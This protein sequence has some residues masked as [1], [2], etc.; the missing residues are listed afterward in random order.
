MPRRYLSPR[1]S[2]HAT[3]QP[4]K[5]RLPSRPASVL[6][7]VFIDCCST[8]TCELII[9]LHFLRLLS[10][11]SASEYLSLGLLLMFLSSP[12][13]YDCHEFLACAPLFLLSN[14]AV[15]ASLGPQKSRSLCDTRSTANRRSPHGFAFLSL[16]FLTSSLDPDI[17]LHIGTIF[18][19]LGQSS[20]SNYR[21]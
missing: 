10:N 14:S 7:I 19:E 4:S 8:A 6:S 21:C 11:I 3:G 12:L 9:E 17:L 1:S 5:A 16:L 2:L 13:P 20:S 18:V 15:N